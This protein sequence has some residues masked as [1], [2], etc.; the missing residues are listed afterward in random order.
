MADI[1]GLLNSDNL[2]G[3]PLTAHNMH[4]CSSENWH[5]MDGND[6]DEDDDSRRTHAQ[7]GQRNVDSI[8][9]YF[10]F[11]WLLV[12]FKREG[13]LVDVTFFIPGLFG[14]VWLWRWVVVCV[15]KNL[16]AKYK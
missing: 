14:R 2:V 6:D 3:L 9:F 7:N 15:G 16:F 5:A 1:F 4:G 13:F 10:L 11:D 12:G 8:L